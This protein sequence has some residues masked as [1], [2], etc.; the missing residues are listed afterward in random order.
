[1][2]KKTIIISIA[3]ILLIV[4]MVSLL[5]PLVIPKHDTARLTG[6]YYSQAGDNDVIFLGDCE[7][8]ETFIPAIL[9]EKYGISS[10]V[11]GTPQQLI[12]QSYYILEETLLQ[13]EEK[14]KAVVFNVYSLKYGTPQSKENNR[15]TLNTMKWSKTKIDAIRASM[16]DGESFIEYV[17]PFLG[18]HGRITS[19]TS[20]D[21]KYWFNTESLP[22]YSDSGYLMNV[23]INGTDKIVTEEDAG[24]LA[25]SE[26]QFSEVSLDYLDK[27]YNLCK[28]NDV[29]LILVKAPTNSFN[30]YWYEE[31]EEQVEE[32]AETN[33]LK[34][35]NLKE[36]ESDI[37]IDWSVDTHDKGFHLNVYGAEKAT[38]YFGKILSEECNIPNRKDDPAI[39][40]KWN[41]RVKIYNE[42][43]AKM[44]ADEK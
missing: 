5:S 24:S 41:N 38:E 37:G 2:K 11:R 10:Y 20:R 14:P 18:H 34:Y 31:Y 40:D 1:M 19:L 25:T 16:L 39:N 35:Y 26:S 15:Y 33:G 6:E 43:K 32:Y 13:C 17:I 7:V 9:W 4:M 3:F 30:V 28:E 8:Y 21:F 27:M 42:R 12:W 29:E 36:C 44:E 23:G 22:I